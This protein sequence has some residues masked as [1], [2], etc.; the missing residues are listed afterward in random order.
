MTFYIRIHKRY[1][2]FSTNILTYTMQIYIIN[3]QRVRE[4][5]KEQ[6]DTDLYMLKGRCP[7][8]KPLYYT[9]TLDCQE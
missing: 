3:I 1:S 4:N 7:V 9:Y 8:S 6:R 5:G 2:G